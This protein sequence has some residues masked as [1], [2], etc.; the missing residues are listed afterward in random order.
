MLLPPNTGP[1][2]FALA[3]SDLRKIAGADVIV[4]NGFGLES[5]LDHAV[6]SGLK[7]GALRIVAAKGITP[8]ENPPELSAGEQKQ[9]DAEGEETGPNPH[10]WLDPILAIKETE[11]IRDGLMARDSA[12]ADAYLANANVFITRLRN[13]DDEIGRATVTLPNKRMLTFHD[14][15]PYFAARYQ[16]EIVGT[17]EAF[18]GREPTP[19]YLQKLREIIASKNVRV[20]FSE[21]QY[22]PQILR[23]LS[24]D[25]KLPIVVIDPMETGDPSA[26][27]YEDVMRKN[28]KS[29]TDALK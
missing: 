1:H 16:F 13:L 14:S 18:P 26:E 23:S 2:D 10:V 25:L 20:L 4:E 17:V 24:E 6:Q 12:N 28:L 9:P 3:P 21:P 5:W 29:L 8:L 15:F 27:Y 22:S 7:Q 11:N 19:R